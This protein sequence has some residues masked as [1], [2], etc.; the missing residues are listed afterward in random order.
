MH[1]LLSWSYPDSVIKWERP[2]TSVPTVTKSG[3][4]IPIPSFNDQV[5]VPLLLNEAT[6]VSV[7]SRLP[8]P[9]TFARSPGLFKVP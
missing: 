8:T 2:D 5:A 6:F 4:S 9:I 1:W 3:L 7:L